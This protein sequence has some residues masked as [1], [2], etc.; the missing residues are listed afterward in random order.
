MVIAYIAH[1]QA[2]LASSS[3]QMANN[4]PNRR[5]T[6]QFVGSF[7]T[8]T[9]KPIS[10]TLDIGPTFDI[11]PTLFVWKNSKKQTKKG[12]NCYFSVLKVTVCLTPKVLLFTGLRGKYDARA[13]A[14]CSQTA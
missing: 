7:F 11:R 6:I 4:M 5:I 1:T 14:D 13:N 3:E 10:P 2:R 9:M 8:S 12:S